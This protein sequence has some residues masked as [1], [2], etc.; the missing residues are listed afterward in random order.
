LRALLP[1]AELGGVGFTGQPGLVSGSF[2]VPLGTA[3]VYGV[4][5]GDTVTA[6]G[7]QPAAA[8]DLAAV[9]R[10]IM[11]AFDLVLVDWCRCATVQPASI[12]SYLA[13]GY[14]R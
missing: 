1:P 6:L 9:L 13:A 14:S 3:W 5:E 7:V 12:G 4:V 2:A 10:R 11:E 8:G